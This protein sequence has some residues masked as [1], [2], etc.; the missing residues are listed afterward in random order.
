MLILLT[1]GYIR[2][3]RGIS[4]LN[5]KDQLQL[6]TR[7]AC[8]KQARR[9]AG[10]PGGRCFVNHSINVGVAVTKTIFKKAQNFY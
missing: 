5:G 2:P 1:V 9:Y 4:N 8:F 7:R 3:A 6:K 10:Y